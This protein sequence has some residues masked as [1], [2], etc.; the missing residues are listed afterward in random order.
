MS[1]ALILPVTRIFPKLLT[2]AVCFIKRTKLIG[3]RLNV[4]AQFFL[5]EG[6]RIEAEK[7]AVY[8]KRTKSFIRVCGCKHFD[9]VL[10]KSHQSFNIKHH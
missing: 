6:L 3:C 2:K 5:E 8:C 9:F 7:L 10:D 1:K 4:V